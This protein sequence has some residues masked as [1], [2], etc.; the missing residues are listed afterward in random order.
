V[1]QLHQAGSHLLAIVNDI[2][3]LSKADAGRMTLATEPFALDMVL[4]RV[5]A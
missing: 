1:G 4:S 2:L 3:D 5:Q